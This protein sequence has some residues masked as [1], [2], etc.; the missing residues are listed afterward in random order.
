M[1]AKITK[2]IK[3][4]KDKKAQAIKAKARKILEKKVEEGT[5]F[6][7][8]QYGEALRKLGAYDRQ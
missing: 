2:F 4:R 3:R 5:D 1:I 7:I 8:Q 6:V